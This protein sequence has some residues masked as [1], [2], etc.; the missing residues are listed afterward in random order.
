MEFVSLGFWFSCWLVWALV[1]NKENQYV[2]GNRNT[3]PF[4][5]Y[6]K[7]TQNKKYLFQLIN[8]LLRNTTINRNI[9]QRIW[10]LFNDFDVVVL[11]FVIVIMKIAFKIP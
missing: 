11:L 3:E 8:D 1:E 5:V 6:N 4:H 2:K 9:F 10:F 7:H